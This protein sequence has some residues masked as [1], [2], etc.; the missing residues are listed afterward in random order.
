MLPG[1]D[2]HRDGDEIE[3][4]VDRFATSSLKEV[5]GGG[6]YIDS[7]FSTPDGNRIYFTFS[8]FRP[9]VLLGV[10][11]PASCPAAAPLPGHVSI[12]GLEWNTD[13]YYV[14]WDGAAW[15]VPV[16][17]GVNT[18]G[19]ECCVWVN[20]DE[21]EIIFYRDTDLD[22]DG[23]DG[24]LGLPATGNY[25]A[26]RSVKT[27][28]W[29][30]PVPLPGVYGIDDQGGGISRTDIHKAPSKNL[31]LWET[32][33]QGNKRLMFG[34]WNGTGYDAP[35]LIPGSTHEDTQVWVSH[36]ETTLV[37]N[38]RTADATDLFKM[39]R[40]DAASAWDTPVQIPTANFADPM[41]KRIWG[42][43][44]FD[45]TLTHLLFVRFNTM[46][47]TCWEAEIMHA[48]G[49]LTRGYAAPVR[50]N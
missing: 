20:D 23:T 42:E 27:A 18:L 47:A 50:L 38:H 5:L 6:G 1:C 48:A 39:T 34:R 19:M 12:P 43:P 25:V 41:G 7:I 17:V 24:D 22:G 44:T 11:P 15:S 28:A 46:D 49:D 3:V 36:D 14:E 8:I 26:T 4:P 29:E 35:A 16:N 2:T 21:T 13:L 37:Y 31:Y 30:T 9:L 32:D 10:T 33:A 45:V 40:A